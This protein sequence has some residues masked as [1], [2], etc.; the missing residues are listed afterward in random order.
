M[1][2]MQTLEPR[3]LLASVPAGFT[4]T[5]IASNL[6]SPT[7]MSFAPDGR[8]FISQQTGDLRI[9]KN[10]QLLPTPFVS[11]KVDSAGERGLLGVA[12][13][14]SFSSNH[15]VYIYYTVPAHRHAAAH[16]RV[17]RFT[18][19]GDVAAKHSETILLDLTS[20]SAATNHNGGSLAFGPDGKLYIGVGDNNNGANSQDITNLLGKILR[21]NPAGSI[22]ADNPF[23]KA[24][25]TNKSIWAIGLRNPFSL[26]FQPITGEML[27]N[28]VGEH[29][30]EEIN[31]G[32]PG[33]NYGWPNSEGP[34]R[35]PR[36]RAPIFYYTHG[37]GPT[38]GDA[39]V[40]S[41]FYS[42]VT[43]TFPK[44]YEG[45][46]FFADLTSG[47]I[48]R[49]DPVSLDTAN[50]ATGIDTPVALAVNHDGSLYYLAR[51]SGEDTGVVG[52]IQHS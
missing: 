1:A 17:S 49:I 16:N 25:G 44:N 42:P 6:A 38:I 22:P 21:I 50:F 36:Y 43:R 32:V 48:R 47:W 34:T 7:T 11:L 33:A 30:Y 4:D 19:N 31:Q 52:R 45:D 46:Y 8:L 35:R 2:T 10:N 40:G 15:F 39:I 41:T 18:A 20:L 37:T 29:T 26:S 13:D 9:L 24:K 51:G 3:L 23:P 14:P 28:D 12:F 5:T 27:I